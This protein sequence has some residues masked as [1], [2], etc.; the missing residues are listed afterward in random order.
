M[1]SKKKGQTNHETRI[2]ISFISSN[3]KIGRKYEPEKEK[4]HL[5]VTEFTRIKFLFN[6]FSFSFL[7]I[8]YRILLLVDQHLILSNLYQNMMMMILISIY[9]IHFDSVLVCVWVCC[10]RLRKKINVFFRNK[11]TNNRYI[12]MMMIGSDRLVIKN[13]NDDRKRKKKKW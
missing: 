13:Q 7:E 9:V 3:S 2:V 11:Q 10:K 5:L 4:N 8:L 12:S 6:N 1:E